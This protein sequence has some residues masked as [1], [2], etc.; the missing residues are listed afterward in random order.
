MVGSVW[1]EYGLAAALA[2]VELPKSTWSYQQQ[3]KGSYEQ[4]YA[5]LG[6]VLK[7]IAQAHP[8]YGYFRTTAELKKRLDR[9]VNY[10]VVQRLHQLYELKL[11]R[12]TRA[13]QLSRLRQ[14]ILQAGPRAGLVAQLETIGLFEV[15]YTDF[16][17]LLYAGG[18]RKAFLMPIIGRTSKF[19][20]GWAVGRRANTTLA[21]AAWA[22]AK[23]T[24]TRLNVTYTG[25][26]VHHDQD[27][28][29]TGYGWTGRLLLKDKA[30]LSYAKA[31]DKDNPA[32]ESF[33][34]R[35]KGENGALFLE[36][37]TLA[38]LQQLVAERM[39]Y[40]NVQRRHSTLG[41]LSPLTFIR[42]QRDRC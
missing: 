6:P 34:G 21:L 1:P 26:I 18:R 23:V 13:P 42:Q 19:V 29:Y 11:R 4:K 3:Q 10:K 16:A 28:V 37:Q 5:H 31:G 32:M 14:V 20:F 33:N 30:R 25:L 9:P 7:A 17:E 22:Q 27:A 15:V 12:Q 36:A 24:L 35:F 8:A 2:A 40:Y 39:D 41:Y 38:D